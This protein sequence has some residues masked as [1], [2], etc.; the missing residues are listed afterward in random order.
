MAAESRG[1]DAPLERDLFDEAF[2]FDFFQAVRLLEQLH[3][4]R[5]PIGGEGPSAREA[6][7]F[8]TRPT[9]G[10]PPSQLETIEQPDAPGTPARMTVAFMGLSGPSGVLPHVYNEL[11]IERRRAGDHT[12]AAFLDLFHHR[13]ISLFYRAWKKHH[14]IVPDTRRGDDAFASHVFSLM[15]LGIA[16]LRDRQSFPDTLLL[17]YGGFFSRQQRPAVV[18]EALLSDVFDVKVAVEQFVGQWLRLEADDLSTIGAGGQHNA[19][20]VNVVVGERV[21]D[22]QG[23]IT[24]RLGPLTF[25]QFRAFLPDGNGFRFLSGLVRL[26]LGPELH[27]LIRPVLA[28]DEVPDCELGRTPGSGSRLG[29]FAWL[30]SAPLERDADQ[31][32]FRSPR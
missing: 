16:P 5:I 9:L 26:F 6:V 11:L 30:K 10:F 18:L 8:L 21:W 24:V 19:L 1:A 3:P 7:R 2:R 20:G 28:A 31:A 14:V 4:D 23:T 27:F 17:R 13:L 15:G 12:F 22:E 25:P 29:R 32:V